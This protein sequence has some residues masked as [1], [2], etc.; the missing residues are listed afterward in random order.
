MTHR[1]ISK[2]SL[3]MISAKVWNSWFMVVSA[4]KKNSTTLPPPECM[5]I[6][7]FHTTSNGH[8]FPLFTFLFCLVCKVVILKFYCY[9]VK[10]WYLTSL[11]CCWFNSI[12]PLVGS[13]AVDD[14]GLLSTRESMSA[15]LRQFG[16][17]VSWN[18]CREWYRICWK[19]SIKDQL[20]ISPSCPKYC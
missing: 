5:Q 8:F 4:K 15:D 6:F 7:K 14:W 20:R 11:G 10:I 17:V 16:L 12:L 1:V 13:D 19:K 3:E 2:Q 18:S 9:I